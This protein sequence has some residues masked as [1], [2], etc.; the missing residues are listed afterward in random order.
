MTRLGWF[1]FTLACGL[2]L[3]GVVHI[4]AVLL[5]P[6]FAGDGP[7]A[8][9][10]N[11]APLHQATLLPAPTP[12]A[13]G[14]AFTDPATAMSICP[15]D[16]DREPVRVRI[17]AGDELLTLSF[18][19]PDGRVFYALSD[20]AAQRGIIDLVLFTLD[21]LGEALRAEDEDDAPRDVRLLSPV[22]RGFVVARVLA[23]QPT[24]MPDARLL[25]SGLTCEP[26]PNVLG[27]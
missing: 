7:L 26:D 11:D 5:T 16:L 8:R 12:A 25:A 23:L 27:K 18:H 24:D 22:R 10:L 21:Q 9:M 4:A 20:R 14:L 15:Y 19:S 1:L 6:A 17:A 2:V 3:A 13:P